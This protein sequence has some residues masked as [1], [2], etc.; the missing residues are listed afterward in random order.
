MWGK[1]ER[2][3][4]ELNESV[5]DTLIASNVTIKGDISFTGGI[6]ISGS[7]QG[8]VTA[9][10]GS[11]GRLWLTEEGVIKG[12]VSAPSITINGCVEGDVHSLEHLELASKAKVEGNVFYKVVEMAQGAVVNG[13]LH[14]EEK[15]EALTSESPAS[16]SEPEI[17]E[18]I[19]EQS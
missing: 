6:Q 13:K 11:D 8:N 2:G 3:F 1:K 4:S 14:K 17:P 10:H 15:V 19:A 16:S 12:Q 5:P 7:V 18:G 9:E